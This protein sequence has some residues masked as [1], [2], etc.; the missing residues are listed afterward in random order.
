MNDEPQN[1]RPDP[2]VRVLVAIAAAGVA[3]IG[4]YILLAVIGGIF[5]FEVPDELLIVAEAMV[6]VMFMPMAYLVRANAFIE[7]D[8]VANLMPRVLRR[9]LPFLSGIFG[10]IFFGLLAWSGWDAL[11]TAWSW[12]TRHMSTLNQPEWITRA[13]LFVGASVGFCYQLLKVIG[14][15]RPRKSSAK[16]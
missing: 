15:F 11:S 9:G 3:A 4:V 2:I 7:V 1:R 16:T 10:L 8:V 6:F 12:G 14:L 5:R 13:V